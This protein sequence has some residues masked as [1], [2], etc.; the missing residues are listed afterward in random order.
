VYLCD[1]KEIKQKLELELFQINKMTEKHLNK[2]PWSLF[3]YKL[4]TFNLLNYYQLNNN[5]QLA[6]YDHLKI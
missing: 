2:L 1:K 4:D 3:Y 5:K 6:L